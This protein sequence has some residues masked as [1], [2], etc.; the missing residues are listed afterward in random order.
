MLNEI[1]NFTCRWIDRRRDLTR[2]AFASF[3]TQPQ[4]AATLL[5]NWQ[6]KSTEC[7]AEDTNDLIALFSGCS[8]I[9][10]AGGLET[11]SELVKMACMIGKPGT[12]PTRIPV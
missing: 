9:I 3:E 1:E 6:K 7:L 11:E 2:S 5:Q 8:E 4:D 10:A 12:L